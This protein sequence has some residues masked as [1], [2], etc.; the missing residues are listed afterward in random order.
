MIKS[1]QKTVYKITAVILVVA[2]VLG[3]L[4]PWSIISYAYTAQSA[5]MRNP[6]GECTNT[7]QTPSESAK[8]MNSLEVGKPVMVTNEVIGDDGEL[9]YELQYTTKGGTVNVVAYCHAKN[10]RLDSNAFVIATGVAAVDMPLLHTSGSYGVYNPPAETGTSYQIGTVPAG[11]KMYVTDSLSVNGA[12]MYRGYYEVEGVRYYGWFHNAYFTKDAIVDLPTDAT[13]EEGLRLQGFPESY[14]KPLA[15]LHEQYPQWVFEPVHT[16][17]EWDAF[18]RAESIKDRC[19]VDLS[20]DDAKKSTETA[21]YNWET[22]VWTGNVDGK[23]VAAHPEYI[24]YCADP[25]N[26]F[27][28]TYIFMFESLSYSDVF[29]RDGVE[30][31]L[32]GT[33]MKDL[34]TDTDGAQW[35]YSDVFLAVGAANGVSPYHLATR[36]R[37]EQGTKGT[38]A[39]ISGTYKGYEGYFNYFNIGA[40]SSSQSGVIVAGLKYAKNQGWDTR[41][42]SLNGGAYFLGKNYIGVGQDTR[43]TQKFDVIMQ[44]GL[45]DHQYMQTV[46]AAISESKTAAAAYPEEDRQQPFVFKIPVYLNMPEEACQFTTKG[47]RNNYLSSLSVS[48]FSLTPTFSGATTEYS[49]VVDYAVEAITVDSLPVASTST[50]TG[51]GSYPLVPGL[52]VIQITCTSQSGDPKVYTLNITR[53]EVPD[54]VYGITSPIYTI[55]N[56]ITGVEPGTTTDVFMSGITG[57]NATLKLQD[58]NGNEV[59]GAVATG[60]KVAM[61]AGDTVVGWKEIV[62]YGDNNGDSTIDI[63]DLIRVNRH[64]LGLANLEGAYVAAAD[65]NKDGAVDILDLIILNRHI[66]GLTTI[67]QQ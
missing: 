36:V 23:R 27:D 46:T 12:M 49:I 64:I 37:Q 8:K 7:R 29:T 2:T 33:F 54:V 21:Y 19:V 28:P 16:G 26:F 45:Y 9:W 52:N 59:S 41:Y 11:T 55:G 56:Y 57:E 4:E 6:S 63:L 15:V 47:N 53:Q 10:V 1:I 34:V 66:L 60:H 18:I 61:L 40:T 62:V 17:I 20:V 42:K 31:I 30:A 3:M 65:V 38:S 58:A 32:K 5:M 43:Y 22:N 67:Q 24:A 48:G 25:R 50:V 44:G 51:N 14:I 13:F 39:L 35:Y